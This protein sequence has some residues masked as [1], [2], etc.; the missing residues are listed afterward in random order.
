MAVKT[1]HPDD[2]GDEMKIYERHDK[3][4]IDGYFD[5]DRIAWRGI[6]TPDGAREIAKRLN[7]LADIM[8]GK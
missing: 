4:H 8:E 2:N 1:I 7:D 6:Y 5:D 3:I